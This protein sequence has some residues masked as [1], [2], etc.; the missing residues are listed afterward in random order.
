MQKQ[1]ILQLAIVS[2]ELQDKTLDICNLIYKFECYII[3]ARIINKLG[4]KTE[5][6][7]L[8]GDWNNISKLESSLQSIELDDNT[9]IILK[10]SA[11]ENNT[12]DKAQHIML[13]HINIISHNEANILPNLYNF[14]EANELNILNITA[15]NNI[16]GEYKVFILN[17][18]IEINALV[19]LND[20]REQFMLFC[21]NLNIDGILDPIRPY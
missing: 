5:L 6:Y 7:V 2:S 13:Y 3:S 11:S 12:K 1:K 17:A 19:S 20:I 14:C 9:K 15:D 18:Q 8:G 10:T 16:S 21:D 4:Q